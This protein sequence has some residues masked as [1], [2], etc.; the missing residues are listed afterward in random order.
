MW[1]TDQEDRCRLVDPA[2]RPSSCEAAS[3][4]SAAGAANP[5]ADARRAKPTRAQRCPTP[6]KS[7]PKRPNQS[8]QRSRTQFQPC[9]GARRAAEDERHIRLS[10][11]PG[12]RPWVRYLTTPSGRL[13]RGR[14]DVRPRY[15]VRRC[16]LSGKRRRVAG[17]SASEG[18]PYQLTDFA[19]S[20]MMSTTRSGCEYIATDGSAALR[21]RRL[22]PGR[23]R[24]WRCRYR[25]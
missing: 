11:A 10:R 16:P 20:R 6:Q 2:R 1:L 4:P 12:W 23:A 21:L 9:L 25:L 3:S 13:R 17:N 8:L 24:P 7:S 22:R 14:P 5:T 19:A 18:R 15:A